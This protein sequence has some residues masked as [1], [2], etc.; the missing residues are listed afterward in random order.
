MEQYKDNRLSLDI[1]VKDLMSRM[2]TEEKAAQLATCLYS[3]LV[4]ESEDCTS[5]RDKK[6]SP[7]RI[8]ERFKNGMGQ[9]GIITS[10]NKDPEDAA[11][12]ANEIQ[13]I[14]VEET[15]LGIPVIFDAEAAVGLIARNSTH[16]PMPIGQ[17]S[18]FDP[19]IVYEAMCLAREQMKSIG[20]RQVFAPVVDISREP[21]W[22]R[23]EETF[24]EDPYLAS[25]MGGVF[26]S[27]LQTD[28]LRNG[29]AATVKHFLAYGMSEGG[30]NMSSCNLS[31]RE[32]LDMVAVPF[33]YAVRE[34]HVA[35]VMSSYN[36][37]DGEPVTGSEKYCR[38]LLR[39]MWGF[40]GLLVQDATA[41][42]KLVQAQQVA[43]TMQQAGIMSIRSGVDLE[44]MAND[45]YG[46]LLVDAVK[47]GLVEERYLDE[48]CSRHLM[49]KLKLGLFDN[50]YID[51][52]TCAKVFRTEDRKATARRL[53]QE[54]M[55]LL[56]NE[57]KLL[58]LS[59]KIKTIAVIGPQGDYLRGL[60]TN[61]SF[62]A[63]QDVFK[64]VAINTDMANSSDD[65]PINGITL[66]EGIKEKISPDTRLFYAE[67]CKMDSA[68][69][70][71]IAQA[72]KTASLADTVIL[73]VGSVSGFLESHNC[74]E[75]RDSATLRLPGAQEKLVNEILKLGK[76][77]IL[78]LIGGRVFG[79]QDVIDRA[80][81]VL[82][83]WAPGEE[84][85]HAAADII[86]GDY[87]PAGRL[88]VSMPRHVGQVP[89]YYNH[90]IGGGKSTPHG[91]YTDMA[92]SP[93][94]PFGHG[95]SYTEFTYKNL[96]ISPEVLDET[97]REVQIEYSVTNSGAVAGDEVAQLYLQDSF[98]SLSRPVKQ[99]YGFARIHLDSG[100]TKKLK[101]TVHL[102]QLAFH[103]RDMNYVVE[104]G[105]FLVMAGTSSEDIRLKGSFY[106]RGNRLPVGEEEKVFVSGIS[107]ES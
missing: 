38:R 101:F 92:C 81:A 73:A 7:S 29:V 30:M 55:V 75:A 96:R 79:I 34:A 47:K 68:D 1:R 97:H 17:A 77:V 58:P 46:D 36:N 43:E 21:R 13:R 35:G 84:G 10:C 85:G 62:V 104:P 11:K 51:I 37:I 106:Y 91:A 67:G 23:M 31:E 25:C 57:N 32:I 98:G 26:I 56:K 87:N 8:R 83:A 66:L 9:V 4:D 65:H 76:S 69:E 54:S 64:V 90:K 2:T 99:L 20:V 40:D 45:C 12:T 70:S 78:V 33:E 60:F 88:P 42:T 18:T 3:E 52:S 80:D 15:R 24:G 53:A 50:P 41:M 39:E 49:L 82:E 63:I 102:H 93:L 95:L 94:Y 6:L 107:I 72:V 48:A 71:M 28:D 86:F 44:L 27:A 59:K 61:Y 74:G 16:N 103:D 89:I 19:G 14:A 100:E 22:G 105:E 5:M